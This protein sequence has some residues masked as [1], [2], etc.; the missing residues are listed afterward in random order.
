MARNSGRE[1]TFMRLINII[2]HAHWLTRDRI[3]AGGH[4]L[5]LIEL[6]ILVMLA[7]WQHGIITDTVAQTSSDFVSFYAAG[8]LALEGTPALAYDQA[9][10]F[11]VEQRYT[12]EGSPYQFFF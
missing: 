11:L 12:V 1:G 3:I 7:L 5:L 10:H 4:V 8:K 6:T 2:R 9:A